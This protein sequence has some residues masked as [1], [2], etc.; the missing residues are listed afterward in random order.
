MLDT[1]ATFTCAVCGQTVVIEVDASAGRH[2]RYVEDCEVCCSP[3]VL[4]IDFDDKGRA[5]VAAE[6]E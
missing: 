3:N 1:T 2:Q 5:W 4:T 6:Q